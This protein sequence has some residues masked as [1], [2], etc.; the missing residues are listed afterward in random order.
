MEY[1]DVN[2]YQTARKKA[3][4]TQ[5]QAAELLD[6]SVSCVRKWEGYA[7]QEMQPDN[8]AEMAYQYNSSIL[9]WQWLKLFSPFAKDIPDI[10]FKGSIQET[11]MWS[12]Q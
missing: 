9:I 8:V 5:E 10:T 3:R 7:I 6:K 2:I 11:A 1:P 4:F 12:C